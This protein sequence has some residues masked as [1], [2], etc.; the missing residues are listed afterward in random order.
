MKKILA[1]FCLGI[2]LVIAANAKKESSSERDNSFRFLDQ[3]EYDVRCEWGQQGIKRLA[4]ISDVIIIVDVLSFST[5][6]DVAT[7][8]G[9]YIF[10]HTK[11]GDIHAFG[12]SVGAIVANQRGQ[13]GYTP[14]PVSFNVI[15]TGTRLVLP[16]SN[17][18]TLSCLAGNKT[19]FLGCL[20]NA[21]AIANV[22]MK[23]GKTIAVIPAGERYPDR[24]I[25][26]A[27]EDF[28][29]AGAIIQYLKGNL[30][31]EAKNAR[32][33]YNNVKNNLY[34][35]IKGCCSGKKLIGRG[36]KKDVKCACQLDESNAV[37]QL[38]NGAYRNVARIKK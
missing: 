35:H 22:A 1:M 36:F 26:F 34:N 20:R 2:T 11:E 6:V 13:A 3:T 15:P 14:S 8:R 19:I 32:A 10:P 5:S 38:V 33:A 37:P 4:P 30:S 21:K 29:G 28:I 18:A 9:A 25:R 24:T 23:L 17:G 12:K 31:P 7:A 16:S 27:T